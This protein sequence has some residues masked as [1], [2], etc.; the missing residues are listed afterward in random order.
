[1]LGDKN[2]HNPRSQII[3]CFKYYFSSLYITKSYGGQNENAALLLCN[4][5]IVL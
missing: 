2:Y 4:I 5:L 1:M 3:N